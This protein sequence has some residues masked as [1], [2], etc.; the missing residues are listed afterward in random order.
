MKKFRLTFL[1]AK[2]KFP[3]LLP[4]ELGLD[5]SINLDQLPLTIS[6]SINQRIANLS[7]HSEH[8]TTV[9]SALKEALNKWRQQPESPNSLVILASPVSPLGRILSESAGGFQED[10][11]FQVKSLEWAV[12]PHDYNKIK[13]QLLSQF[14]PQESLPKATDLETSVTE[15]AEEFLKLLVIPRL[16]WCF[17]RSIGGLEIIE[18]LR[19]LISSDTSQFWLIGCNNWAWQYLDQIYQVSA[20]LGETQALPA[21]TGTQMKEWLQPVIDEI[22]LN[23][24][25]DIAQED[26]ESYQEKYFENLADISLGIETVGAD[27]WIRGLQYPASQTDNLQDKGE[28]LS[29]LTIQKARLP[30]LPNLIPEDRFLLY[31]LLLHGGMSLSH[32]A[33]SLGQ[34]ESLVK[35]RVRYLL[36]TGV[37]RRES[38]L[39]IVNPS[40][41]P[42][43]KTILKNN[44]FLVDE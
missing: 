32:L 1:K 29:S 23:W 43:L 33:L 27:L 7:S 28:E 42:R 41:Y 31:S 44:N 17:L 39:L 36:Q 21:L 3:K 18:I 40:Y 11:L 15:K 22:K 20:Y 25:E 5:S 2:I 37:I 10:N 30:D 19:D 8:Q 38:N 4:T 9:Q 13:T 26:L 35:T 16:E 6:N 24:G 12:Q 14:N 34:T